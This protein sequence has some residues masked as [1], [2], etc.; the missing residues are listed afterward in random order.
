MDAGFPVTSAVEASDEVRASVL[1]AGRAVEATHIGPYDTLAQTYGEM[2]RWTAE[3][4][5][6]PGTDMWEQ[7]LTDPET[8][9]DPAKW[10]TRVLCPIR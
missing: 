4:G 8:E 3:Q 7:Y 5:L 9:P 2:M 6:Q 10:R 1:P